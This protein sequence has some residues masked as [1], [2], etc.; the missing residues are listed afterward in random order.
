M[1]NCCHVLLEVLLQLQENHV[2]CSHR[3]QIA[4]LKF[5]LISNC[6]NYQMTSTVIT[7]S[8]KTRQIN[9]CYNFVTNNTSKKSM[10]VCLVK[11]AGSDS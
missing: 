9:W 3:S 10:K 1:E 8:L 5:I 11:I 4:R 7:L 6:Q 2:K